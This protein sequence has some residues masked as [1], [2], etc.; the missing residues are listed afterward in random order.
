[1]KK[2]KTVGRPPRTDKDNKTVVA[3]ERGTMPGDKRKTYIVKEEHAAKIDAIAFWEQTTV[4]EIVN[5]AFVTK[6]NKYEKE[7]GAIKLPAKKK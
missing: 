2:T 7:N 5:D 3:A 4:K 6:I 1:M